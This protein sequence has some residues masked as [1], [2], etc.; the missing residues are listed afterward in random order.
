MFESVKEQLSSSKRVSSKKV[1]WQSQIQN[2]FEKLY[3][4]NRVEIAKAVANEF[5]SNVIS[6][7]GGVEFECQDLISEFR[8]VMNDVLKAGRTAGIEKSQTLQKNALRSLCT[9]I[10]A[11]FTVKPPSAFGGAGVKGEKDCKGI[12]NVMIESIRSLSIPEVLGE[13]E[14]WQSDLWKKMDETVEKK[15]KSKV[16]RSKKVRKRRKKSQVVEDDYEEGAE[17]EE[18]SVEAPQI[19]KRRAVVKV[20]SSDDENSDE[21]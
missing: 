21:F 1:T 15:K 14:K 2:F 8:N 19:K 13:D 10:G 9:E 18:R 12:Q 6:G 17:E 4:K 5:S 11:Q 3:S 16:K 7:L 20:Q